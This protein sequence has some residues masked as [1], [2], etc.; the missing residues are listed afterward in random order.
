MGRFTSIQRKNMKNM[1]YFDFLEEV[2]DFVKI[3]YIGGE[4]LG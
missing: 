3:F 2:V 4:K 1:K